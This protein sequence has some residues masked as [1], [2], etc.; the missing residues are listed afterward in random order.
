MTHR[1]RLLMRNESWLPTWW[2]LRHRSPAPSRHR[3]RTD[4]AWTTGRA[5]G[6]GCGPWRR[7]PRS[8]RRFRLAAM[9]LAQP[10]SAYNPESLGRPAIAA[11]RWH[12]VGPRPERRSP[13]RG[14]TGAQDPARGLAFTDHEIWELAEVFHDPMAARQV[15]AVSGVSYGRQPSWQVTNAL[16]FW[17][18][19]GGLVSSGLLPDG[20]ERVLTE[21][22][23]RHPANAVFSAAHS[24]DEIQPFANG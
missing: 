14:P 2:L 22:R 19:V 16:Q 17:T 1:S 10:M 13:E 9:A 5:G 3:S 15:L 7:L 8:W 4:V 24:R 11:L 12:H 23:R 6:R 21:A 18:E 20:R